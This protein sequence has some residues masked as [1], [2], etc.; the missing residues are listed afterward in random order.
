[1][2][3]FEFNEEKELVIT[4]GENRTESEKFKMAR[5][6]DFFEEFGSYSI[7]ALAEA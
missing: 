5:S 7:L 6:E 2:L 4:D 1:L 3:T